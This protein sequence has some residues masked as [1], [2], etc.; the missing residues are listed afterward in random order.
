M[1]GQGVG[2]MTDAGVLRRAREVLPSVDLIGLRE[3]VS[4]V[5]L[6]RELGVPPARMLVTGDDALELALDRPVA[7]ADDILGL[8]LRRARYSG[9]DEPAEQAIRRAVGR[10]LRDT[11]ASPLAVPVSFVPKESDLR[12]IASLVPDAA[13]LKDGA[14]GATGDAQW[15]PPRAVAALAG[16]CRAVLTGS[17]HAAVFA[18]AH[19]RPVV[20]VRGSA[21]YDQK[22]TGLADLFG[23]ACRMVALGPDLEQRLYDALRE[24]WDAEP[25]TLHRARRAAQDQAGWSRAAYQQLRVIMEG[26]R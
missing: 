23:P 5:P 21:Y 11:G 17:Y 14:D 12:S 7:P 16:R 19:G 2:P 22:F 8:N 10:F 13:D 25:A 6:L 24:A 4:G 1:M 18:L 15:V 3:R 26:D 20:G 9:I